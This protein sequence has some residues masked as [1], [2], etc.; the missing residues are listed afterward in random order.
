[1]QLEAEW[2]QD[3]CGKQ[4]YDANLVQLSTRFW[5]RGGGYLMLD[6]GTGVIEGNEARPAERPSAKAEILF[7][8]KTI[9]EVDIEGETEEEV[10][11]RVEAWARLQFNRLFVA[12]MLQFPAVR[13]G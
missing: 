1:M 5:P 11:A 6:T 8:G 4:D 9:A 3:C 2:T 10:K 12:L 7:Q 13:H